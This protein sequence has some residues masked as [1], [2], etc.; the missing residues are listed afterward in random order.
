MGFAWDPVKA[1]ANVRKHGVSFE[2]ARWVFLDP[3]R[4]ERLDPG[5]PYGEDRYQVIGMVGGRVFLVVYAE[6][7]DDTRLISARGAIAEERRE[8]AQAHRR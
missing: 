3:L 5:G 6:R 7:C 2:E 8:Y 1:A 4:V